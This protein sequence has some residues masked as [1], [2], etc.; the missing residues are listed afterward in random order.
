M[1]KKIIDEV[2]KKMMFSF[3][4]FVLLGSTFGQAVVAQFNLTF[5]SSLQRK[6]TDVKKMISYA[7]GLASE[8]KLEFL[9]SSTVVCSKS[10]EEVF[11][12]GSE[13]AYEYSCFVNN[14]QD[15]SLQLNLNV[16]GTNS[17]DFLGYVA[18][19]DAINFEGYGSL[20]F[21]IKP[22]SRVLFNV[23]LFSLNKCQY[24]ATNI[25]NVSCSPELD[26]NSNQGKIILVDT[27]N[28]IA[29]VQSLHA[30]EM[31][32]F[33]KSAYEK[34]N[35]VPAAVV[36]SIAKV[37]TFDAAAGGILTSLASGEIV[38][39]LNGESLQKGVGSATYTIAYDQT[40]SKILV[41][42]GDEEVG[43][44]EVGISFAP[45]AVATA[46]ENEDL[47]MKSIVETTQPA[48]SSEAGKE[49]S[50]AEQKDTTSKSVES[51]S[52]SLLMQ[53]ENLWKGVLGQKTS[54]GTK[55]IGYSDLDLSKYKI[56]LIYND[57]KIPVSTIEEGELKAFELSASD[58]GSNGNALENLIFG[59]LDEGNKIIYLVSAGKY[60]KR[61]D[62]GIEPASVDNFLNTYFLAKTLKIVVVA[63]S[64]VIF[65]AQHDYPYFANTEIDG[66]KE[67]II[68][69]KYAKT[70]RFD[71]FYLPKKQLF[72]IVL[73][74][75]NIDK[76]LDTVG[77]ENIEYITRDTFNDKSLSDIKTIFADLATE[78]I[79]GVTEPTK[80]GTTNDRAL[81]DAEKLGAQIKAENLL[82]E[83][84]AQK[85]EFKKMR[86]SSIEEYIL[87]ELQ[88]GKTF[89]QSLQ[90]LSNDK[91]FLDGFDKFLAYLDS[92]SQAYDSQTVKSIAEQAKH[93]FIEMLK[94]VGA[95]PEL[96][97]QIENINIKIEDKAFSVSSL[98]KNS[99]SVTRPSV[100]RFALSMEGPLD[101]NVKII[102]T[103]FTAH[104][105]THKIF[106]ISGLQDK[107]EP[108]VDEQFAEG[109]AIAF[110]KSKGYDISVYENI[111]AV[112]ENFFNTIGVRTIW[113]SEYGNFL[114]KLP[115]R[116]SNYELYFVR[117]MYIVQFGDKSL[118]SAYANPVSPSEIESI[119]GLQ[120]GSVQTTISEGISLTK[121]R[122]DFLEF[123]F[124]NTQLDSI[125]SEDID[126]FYNTHPEYSKM[127]P[128]EKMS[129]LLPEGFIYRGKN[130]ISIGTDGITEG[131][132]LFRGTSRGQ[133]GERVLPAGVREAQDVST[134]D[135]IK[136]YEQQGGIGVY[137]SNQ[138]VWKTYTGTTPEDVSYYI[139]GLDSVTRKLITKDSALWII[140]RVE[141]LK[142]S[143][144]LPNTGG[145]INGAEIRIFDK[146]PL[147]DVLAIIVPEGEKAGIIKNLK[148]PELVTKYGNEL[149]GLFGRPI[150][151][152]II[153][154]KFDRGDG[155][156]VMSDIA[157]KAIDLMK[158][159]LP[160]LQARPS[161]PKKT[162]SF[163]LEAEVQKIINNEALFSNPDIESITVSF[164]MII[165]KQVGMPFVVAKNKDGENKIVDES[166][167][168]PET[169]EALKELET[170][171]DFYRE[172]TV[173]PGAETASE[174][175]QAAGTQATGAETTGASLADIVQQMIDQK[176]QAQGI[177]SGNIF[178][179][180]TAYEL[181]KL[182]ELTE[183][184]QEAMIVKSNLLYFSSS[185]ETARNT[186]LLGLYRADLAQIDQTIADL[187]I[188]EP[189]RLKS[190]VINTLS[191]ENLERLLPGD[192]T[193]NIDRSWS[194][195]ASQ[196]A[197]AVEEENVKSNFYGYTTTRSKTPS[198][199]F[200][201][202]YTQ[203]LNAGDT[204]VF[205]F[206]DRTITYTKMANGKFAKVTNLEAIGQAISETVSSDKAAAAINT[207][208]IK[209][210]ERAQV[211]KSEI[212][213]NGRD[214]TVT[215]VGGNDQ[216]NVP[217][218]RIPNDFKNRYQGRA[219]STE[220]QGD[221]SG[222]LKN[223]LGK[224]FEQA[225]EPSQVYKID[226]KNQKVE[227]VTIDSGETANGKTSSAEFDPQTGKPKEIDLKNS[228]G[229]EELAKELGMKTDLLDSTDKMIKVD[230]KNGDISTEA[231]SKLNED[232]AK[233]LNV[234]K[235]SKA[236]FEFD[237]NGEVKSATVED[238]VSGVKKTMKTNSETKGLKITSENPKTGEKTVT[239]IDSN[240][241][242]KTVI[243]KTNTEI[244]TRISKDGVTIKGNF[245]G[246]NVEITK[247]LETFT[248]AGLENTIKD[249]FNEGKTL[250]I[251][252]KASKESN[253]AQIKVTKDGVEILKSNG[254]ITKFTKEQALDLMGKDEFLGS[255]SFEASV[256]EHT[257]ETP[258]VSIG[259]L[260]L[261]F[262]A[263]VLG[264]FANDVYNVATGQKPLGFSNPIE[265]QSTVEYGV[266]TAFAAMAAAHVVGITEALVAGSTPVFT[267]ATA[268]G[269]EAIAL[270]AA[271]AF[272]IEAAPFA[273][274][275]SQLNGNY[276]SGPMMVG[277][278]VVNV[279]NQF[280][281]GN[282]LVSPTGSDL[283][284]QTLTK[285]ANDYSGETILLPGNSV[286]E[287]VYQQKFVEIATQMAEQ[288]KDVNEIKD[289]IAQLAHDE[290]S[291][292][293]LNTLT[294]STVQ[295]KPES[296]HD[297]TGTA[298]ITAVETTG[299][300]FKKLGSTTDRNEAN[301]L[302]QEISDALG[303]KGISATKQ[304]I[305]DAAIGNLQMQIEATQN[306][307]DILKSQPRSDKIG[308]S[309][310]RE[311]MGL[312]D[313]R[314]TSLEQQQKEFEA[315]KKVNQDALGPTAS[316][317]TGIEGSETKFVFD[318]AK[319]S[320]T[321]LDGGTT[322]SFDEKSGVYVDKTISFDTEGNPYNKLFEERGTGSDAYLINSG[323]RQTNPDGSFYDV[324]REGMG[325]STET[326][327]I[328]S[329]GTNGEQS[330]HVIV[331]ESKSPT[332]K[333]S[334]IESFYDAN[335]KYIGTKTVSEDGTV[336]VYDANGKV[337]SNTKTD[338]SGQSSLS[339]GDKTYSVDL[340]KVGNNLQGTFT[341]T[342]N[343]EQ[344]SVSVILDNSG[345]VQ[346][347]SYTDP[348]NNVPIVV[349]L[350]QGTVTAT[351][352]G[353]NG[354][355]DTTVTQFGDMTATVQ[356]DHT[357]VQMSNG[358]I[359]TQGSF[360][361]TYDKTT[362]IANTGTEEIVLD[363]NSFGQDIAL[364]TKNDGSGGQINSAGVK[365][366]I[367]SQ[368]AAQLEGKT[369]TGFGMTSVKAGANLPSTINVGS[370][371]TLTQ[372][373]GDQYVNSATGKTVTV[374]VDNSGYYD[375]TE[376]TGGT[377]GKTTT[378]KS[379]TGTSG[380]RS[381][382]GAFKPEPERKDQSS[383]TG[384]SGKTTTQK[385]LSGTRGVIA[386]E[387]YPMPQQ[388]FNLLS[389]LINNLFRALTNQQNQQEA[390]AGS[391]FG[392]F[393][394]ETQILSNISKIPVPN[395][396]QNE[397]L[398]IISSYP[399]VA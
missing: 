268:F 312:Q 108:I 302:A 384:T 283:L 31:L 15:E 356:N 330:G 299:D 79:P 276:Y 26:A 151:D 20:K 391:V 134:A 112:Q 262:D 78:E 361:M 308:T 129:E 197:A 83:G 307:I 99:I 375:W 140:D 37:Q 154:A 157:I 272:T 146:V 297:K 149:E 261:A 255:D 9:N 293:T 174:G 203:S 207:D 100:L 116:I 227:K 175:A 152:V 148:I 222:D 273:Y 244:Q 40:R 118:I 183:I 48:K 320:Y 189:Q 56:I 305:L 253:F 147:K 104:E 82:L 8:K 241:V 324:V 2:K 96:I 223:E 259:A 67:K 89:E 214:G 334:S 169:V 10:G 238:S 226:M 14:N 369:V 195:L 36:Y 1:K 370:G 53:W 339:F 292:A 106:S 202:G 290:A 13:A 354:E 252:S 332:G 395:I 158:S 103:L 69:E 211:V 73:S 164:S 221:L 114:S 229:T 101:D 7:A 346:S 341:A 21:K 58:K 68:N 233:K 28:F 133:M 380:S 121:F 285:M 235:K 217:G 201:K 117:S 331:T 366:N 155:N 162:L 306:Q 274:A 24:N 145:A 50:V 205:N 362:G 311:M 109:L 19:N 52:N 187:G 260:D 350:Q 291:R 76:I 325:S 218:D 343:D 178:T 367:N 295:I 275:N 327:K 185:S 287:K 236:S 176:N 173:V 257:A 251:F 323:F 16:L 138:G 248:K 94:K 81:S 365:V 281:L 191:P 396:T 228:A 296:T 319:N 182:S 289:S 160:T 139:Q 349:N 33:L 135:L 300:L 301:Q 321:S 263:V 230:F 245:E 377:S 379:G 371:V 150:S 264:N 335:G 132:F 344:V 63:H 279:N 127:F 199:D 192:M 359:I 180:Y 213:V 181:E 122:N 269:P 64:H 318:A 171:F 271:T 373:S 167:L 144:W 351:Y 193:Q 74:K 72:G 102:T 6:F 22:Q 70:V 209:S 136:M 353:S 75:E 206:V 258:K 224:W 247:P 159:E 394:N 30:T 280:L 80:E 347:V 177:S 110:A 179:Q 313:P 348:T 385:R 188:S 38:R 304:E 165:G 200:W 41:K 329:F 342:I 387:T 90:D 278:T 27:Q 143:K 378:Q 86:T 12:S 87:K 163:S 333:T 398:D 95:D 246:S 184:A 18:S 42:I 62:I 85:T 314:V 88:N 51:W 357:T 355:V 156:L 204:I 390:V 225:K 25:T 216:A 266:S 161:V 91:Q 130:G 315:A 84:I 123:F 219:E 142:E 376:T 249:A 317:G 11:G 60:L 240:G 210:M 45:A 288:G 363:K 298:G 55:E 141:A 194:N 340:E 107:N 382:T 328:D 57:Q 111:R 345:N 97:N 131:M 43:A 316:L 239:E 232:M 35:G 115:A 364:I 170:K 286:Y 242:A 153:E 186:N 277:K 128:K 392:S 208:S 256:F 198:L 254:D 29:F 54:E 326:F 105:L 234:D 337:I 383:G 309:D 166:E 358:E 322:L 3:I 61:Y 44:A 397:L 126:R 196:S 71:N 39:L 4:T 119:L 65:D 267:A 294:K 237:E 393:G 310:V 352:K 190:D 399:T 98:D 23:F 168:S 338:G 270:V 17:F 231:M 137:D 243:E 59:F 389:D 250:D 47:L 388:I 372:A 284:T 34:I 374:I 113:G 265:F 77:K 172:V 125:S 381:D 303:K 49:I 215:V 124:D 46:A 212:N 360:T 92:T 282:P 220:L 368:T 386:S 32:L 336:K 66:I 93:D 5:P 120:P